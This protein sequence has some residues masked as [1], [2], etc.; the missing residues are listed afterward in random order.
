MSCERKARH[1]KICNRCV[2]MN[3]KTHRSI[4]DEREFNS[5]PLW[6]YDKAKYMCSRKYRFHPAVQTRNHVPKECLYR[7]EHVIDDGVA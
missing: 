6:G 7:L 1:D 5:C 2:K 3:G 4:F